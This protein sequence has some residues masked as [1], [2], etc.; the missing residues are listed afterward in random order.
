MWQKG[1]KMDK[2]FCLILCVGAVGL[3]P[4]GD[5]VE[6]RNFTALLRSELTTF[7]LGAN[8]L[9]RMKSFHPLDHDV[10]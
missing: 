7:S 5:N 3:W 2:N 4:R 9:N 6:S 10:F 8:I 1:T